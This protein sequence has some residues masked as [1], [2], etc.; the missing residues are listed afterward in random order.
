MSGYRR[1]NK[2]RNEC[3]GEKVGIAPIEKKM[4]ESH[5]RGFGYVR[6]RPI[7]SEDLIKWRIA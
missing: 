5:L 2:I 4:V 6:R 1:H 3:I 7:G